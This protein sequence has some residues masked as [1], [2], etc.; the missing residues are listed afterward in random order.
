M[1][2][3][4]GFPGLTQAGMSRVNDRPGDARNRDTRLIA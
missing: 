3:E 1:N 4:G 2:E